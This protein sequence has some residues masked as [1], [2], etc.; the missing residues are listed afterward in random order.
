MMKLGSSLTAAAMLLCPGWAFSEVADS[1]A[2]GFTVKTSITIQASPDEVYR[3]LVHNIGE[4][5]SPQHT[6]SGDARNLSI[7]EKPMGCFCEALAGLGQSADQGG[8]QSGG[9]VR[10]MEVVYFVPGKALV[11]SG[12]LGP[13]QSLATAG[14]M[15]IRLSP[16]DTGTNLEVAYTVAGYAPAGM[17]TWAAPV[18]AVLTEQFARLKNYI[19]RGSPAPP[20]QTAPD[21]ASS[22]AP[23]AK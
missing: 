14:S 16:G 6:F 15:T 22:A 5:W 7:E 23:P 18:D 3:R 10:H 2:N 20:V 19:E 21:I 1:S 13:L 8:G 9:A 17:N 4:W 11:L 12:A